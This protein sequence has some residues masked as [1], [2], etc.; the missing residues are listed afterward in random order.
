MPVVPEAPTIY[1][2]PVPSTTWNGF[3]D[4]IRFLQAKPIAQLRQTSS[5]T[6]TTGTFTPIQFQAEAFDLD[7]DGVG[8]HDNSTNNSRYTA[9]YRGYYVVG[10]LVTFNPNGTGARHVGLR[11]NGVDLVGSF[12]SVVPSAAEVI[13]ASPHTM[14][15]YL[16]VNDY[17]EVL[18][19]QAS[20]GN[21]GTYVASAPWQSGMSIGWD[22]IQ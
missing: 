19:Y 5:Q 16:D 10:G 1:D 15:I 11:V 9:R 22:R 21:L 3:R 6:L 12:K 18:A 7:P 13:G 4:A 8:G 17:V 14:R 2:G 20:G